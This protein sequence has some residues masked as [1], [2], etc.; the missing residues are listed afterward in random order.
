MVA[1]EE[2][3]LK[4]VQELIKAGVNVNQSDIFNTVMKAAFERQHFEVGKEL[5]R[6]NVDVD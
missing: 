2:G 1:C 4:V 6:A 5:I 3:H